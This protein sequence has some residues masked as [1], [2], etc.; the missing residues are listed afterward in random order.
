MHLNIEIKARCVDPATIRQKLLT[1]GAD[2]RGEDHQVD[3]YFEA[4]TGRL[5][6]RQGNIENSLIHYERSD[7]RG[8][9]ASQVRLFPVEPDRSESLRQLLAAALGVRQVVDKRRGIYFIGNVKFHIDQV[10]GL[11]SF[12][13]IEAIDADGT[14]GEAHLRGQCEHYLR[15][16][17]IA[18]EDLLTH[19]YGDMVE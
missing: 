6:L 1:A 14:L 5:K 15:Y 4:P 13:E 16:L 17:E 2:F 11:G 10:A 3:T 7:Q 9:K 19:S 8:P 12:V 18:P